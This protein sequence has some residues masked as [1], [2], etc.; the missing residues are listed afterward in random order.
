MTNDYRTE[1]DLL[2][3]KEI[4]QNLLYGIHTKR[5]EENFSLAN[6][7]VHKELIHA[8]GL[9]KFA[10][11]SVNAELNY[12]PEQKKTTAIL[13]ACQEMSDGLLDEHI[14]VDALQGG[15]G[16]S[17]NMNVNEVLANRALE[18]LGKAHGNYNAVSPLND[19][20][21]HQSTNDTYPTALKIA[22]IKLITELEDTI[23]TT[24][25][26]FQHLEKNFYAIVKVGRTQ[27][28]G[29][30]L[31]T[32]GAEMAAYA[33]SL[34]RDRWRI[35][36]C[37]ERLRV[38]NL[39]GTA[40]GTGIGAPRKYIFR[41]TDKL[42]EITAIN[43]ARAENLLD[44]TQ[45]VDVFVEVS[46]ILKACA[47]N[48]IKISNDLRF[49]SS[50]IATGIGE[51]N[52]PKKQAGSSI[53][54]GKVNPVI[55][56]TVIQA[57]IQVIANDTAITY[58]ASSGH[59]ELNPFLPLIAENLLANIKLLK[60]AFITF[61]NN[62]I[63]GITANNAICQKKLYNSTA[64]LVALLPIL[65]YETLCDIAQ[66]AQNSQKNICAIILAEKLLTKE[67][68]TELLSAETICKLGF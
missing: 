9:V 26:S 22:A 64:I 66:K 56:E 12:W 68:L 43:L 7:P 5:A 21:L 24:Q 6:K 38:I 37:Q 52:I 28:Q 1:T 50:D 2:G 41:V 33:E 4:A 29:A 20:N 18:I 16:T 45:N 3:E 49:L 53:M 25:K 13:Q 57:A 35:Y 40:I 65:S 39:G 62:C 36:K 27:M 17:T 10:C 15:A 44:A 51:I 23:V 34:G 59:L 8:Y 67:K 48:L 55:L 46:G 42:R 61:N 14:I 58:A 30:T 60:N 54:P 11:A 47:T 19:I 63:T 32:L 31:T